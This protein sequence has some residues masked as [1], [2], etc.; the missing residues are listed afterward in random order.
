MRVFTH[1]TLAAATLAH[2][3][4]SAIVAAPTNEENPFIVEIP[5]GAAVNK[6]LAARED[7]PLEC[8]GVCAG[9]SKSTPLLVCMPLH[10]DERLIQ[11]TVA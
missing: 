9:A 2:I 1:C 6:A 4:L 11:C 3:A 10:T 5:I 8:E 7:D